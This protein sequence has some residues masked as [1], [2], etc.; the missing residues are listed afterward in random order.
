MCEKSLC[1]GWAIGFISENFFLVFFFS[2]CWE[3]KD[4][5]QAMN[6][7]LT[8]P[9]AEDRPKV[10]Y[11]GESNNLTWCKEQCGMEP[12]CYA[13]SLAKGGKTWGKKCYARGFGAPE[14]LQAQNKVYS[15]IKMC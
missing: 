8:T 5:H 14:P 3:E 12:L 1:S 11:F 7:L 15:G 2:D 9:G 13:Y 4:L 6:G 10:F